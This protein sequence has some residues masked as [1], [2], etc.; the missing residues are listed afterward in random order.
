MPMIMAQERPLRLLYPFSSWLRGR[1]PVLILGGI[2]H[3]LFS[4]LISL[5]KAG[6][7]LT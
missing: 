4:I 2:K 1:K 6:R 7:M 5:F 3:L